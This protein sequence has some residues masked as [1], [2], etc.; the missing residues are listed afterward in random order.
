MRRGAA[1]LL[2]PVISRAA[3]GSEQEYA[4]LDDALPPAYMA[5]NTTFNLMLGMNPLDRAACYSDGGNGVWD[6]A[7][8]RMAAREAINQLA[9]AQV[10]IDN[11]W[12]SWESPLINKNWGHAQPYHM[13]DSPDVEPNMWDN[14]RLER[15]VEST[16]PFLSTNTDCTDNKDCWFLGQHE[17]DTLAPQGDLR[18]FWN[19]MIRVTIVDIPVE[20]AQNF[21]PFMGAMA[22][23]VA[24]NSAGSAAANAGSTL[25]SA[26][27][28]TYTKRC[29]NT[30]YLFDSFWISTE[31]NFLPNRLEPVE[32]RGRKDQALLIPLIFGLAM[33]LIGPT[34][35]VAII[36]NHQEQINDNDAKILEKEAEIEKKTRDKASLMDQM[37]I[38][39]KAEDK[40][41]LDGADKAAKRK[42]DHEYEIDE[43]DTTWARG[44][45]AAAAQPP[46][47]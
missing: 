47:K 23:Y 8:F 42:K 28:G 11:Q 13:S 37:D 3:P 29:P 43:G 5:A 7:L 34:S 27:T 12:R 20:V 31:D 17:D 46:A 4:N 45:A 14:I 26:T 25:V 36:V 39:M 32:G 19:V 35:I 22:G 24:Y 18:N 30:K 10:A 1:L 16:K 33:M 9:V 41:A 38:Y 21:R 2:L 15:V 6:R 40:L 44:A